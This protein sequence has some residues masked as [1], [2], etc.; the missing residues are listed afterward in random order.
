MDEL[1]R[2]VLVALS[3]RD[4]E[5]YLFDTAVA[6]RP[7]LIVRIVHRLKTRKQGHRQKPYL[8]WMS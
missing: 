8:I 4:M 6:D 2:Q 5:I 3:F 7:E 1:V